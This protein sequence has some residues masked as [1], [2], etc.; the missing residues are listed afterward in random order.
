M[1]NGGAR[2]SLGIIRRKRLLEES[3]RR[4][5]AGQIGGLFGERG[6]HLARRFTLAV[7]CT[8]HVEAHHVAGTLPDRV[9]RRLSVE[10]RQHALLDVSIAPEALHRLADDA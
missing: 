2:V 6:Q 7:D 4:P 8:Q 1:F 10:S 5:R 3:E 9:D